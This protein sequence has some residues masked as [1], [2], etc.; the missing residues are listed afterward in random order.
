MNR[1]AR[2]NG[3]GMAIGGAQ[4]VSEA[5][6]SYFNGHL[7]SRQEVEKLY[8]RSWNRNFKSRL[9][10]G[11]ALAAL[12]RNYRVSFVLLPLLRSFPF[13]L[14]QVIQTTHGKAALAV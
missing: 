2:T 10:T 6:L 8:V 5:I 4:L 3:M 14:R 11:H 1:T 7:S 12:L 13:V 9:R